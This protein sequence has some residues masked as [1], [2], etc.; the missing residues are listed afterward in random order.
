MQVWP[1]SRNKNTVLF[2][3][4]LAYYAPHVPLEATDKYLSRFSNIAETR[5]QHG[6]AMLS[7]IDDGVGLIREKLEENQLDDNTLK[8]FISDNGAPLGI[9]KLDLPI[10]DKDGF[11]DGSL[12]EPMVGEKGMLSEGG[13]RVPYLVS[14][15]G[16]IP[17][18]VVSDT[19]VTTLDVATTSIAAA[20]LEIPI[21]LDGLIY[22]LKLPAMKLLRIVL[23]SGDS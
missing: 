20:G 12:N 4:Y 10:N 11:W 2:F 1:L 9:H 13:I 3:L 15:P 6:L 14:W 16:K 21:D 7:A 5:R 8:F 19:P 23:Y 22:F 17:A 18:G